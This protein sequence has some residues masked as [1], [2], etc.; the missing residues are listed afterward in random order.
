MTS[1]R[2]HG[3]SSFHSFAA[4][5]RHSPGLGRLLAVRLI[6]QLTDGVFQAALLGGVLFNP[7]RHA[8]PLA[9]ALGFAVLLLPYSIIGPFAGA[10][11]D[12]WDRRMVL[13]WANVVR[14][15]MIAAVAIVIAAGSPDVVVLTSA[16]LVTGA[17]RFVASGL[18]AAL[19]HV[20]HRDVI[21]GTNA[22]FTTLGGAML[23]V[24]AGV[25]LL[26]RMVVGDDNVGS[27]QT[28]MVGVLAALLAAAVARRFPPRQLGPDE[29]DDAGHSAV[30]A[31]AVGFL[32]GIRAV[33]H[34]RTAAAALAAIGFHRLV[35]GLNT[36]TLFVFA[37]QAGQGDGLGRIAVVL[38]CVG[39]G[40][41]LAALTTP[42]AVA[43]IGRR[44]TLMS[45]L[46]LGALAQLALLS[47]SMV[48]FCVVAIVIGLVGQTAKL[49]GDAAMQ[50]DVDDTVRGQVFSV[51][52]AVFNVAY[53]VAMILT[54][55]VIPASGESAVL[56]LVGVVIYLVGVLAV[57]LIHPTHL[58]IP[59]DVDP[60]TAPAADAAG[61]PHRPN[62]GADAS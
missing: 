12:H 20:T 25:A 35:F 38:G 40:A 33:V 13:L 55:L 18:S 21:V 59:T 2:T 48:V 1:G 62:S 28:A 19:P 26:V 37:R 52:D 27:A 23:S 42:I 45:A 34:W 47:F 61:G 41:F 43:R 11:L 29:P 5:L 44:A 15:A 60:D 10:L 14:A 8:D 49:C 30:H 16:L 32:H 54:A 39:V 46:A 7:E 56:V 17:S 3:V 36:L 50:V 24:G 22:L 6:S 51:Q 53:V 31:V 58:P 4:S 57:R 9:A